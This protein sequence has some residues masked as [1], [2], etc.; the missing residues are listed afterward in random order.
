M[1][2]ETS[3]AKVRTPSNFAPAQPKICRGWRKA[4][5]VG[6]HRLRH[7]HEVFLEEVQQL[8]LRL[9][10]CHRL[11]GA[12][13]AACRTHLCGARQRTTAQNTC[14]AKIPKTHRSPRLQIC[15]AHSLAELDAR[16]LSETGY[17]RHRCVS[18]WTPTRPRPSCPEVLEAMRPFWSER[19]GNPSSAHQSGQ[20]TRSAVEHARTSVASLL[21]C[22]PK[23]IVFTSGG[24]ESDNLA[25][26]GF[27][28]P[29]LEQ[30]RTRPP[31]HH[32][33]R[34]PRR[35]LRR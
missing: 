3:C 14:G 35:T 13:F 4:V 7:T 33:D 30:T 5:L 18:T 29:C 6:R 27:C 23:E 12:T 11:P 9:R 25:L 22:S 16:R 19:Y 20:R 1:T 32:A 17:S 26:S 2:W 8:V 15:A 28:S 10:R 21:H 24:T 34:T 31:H